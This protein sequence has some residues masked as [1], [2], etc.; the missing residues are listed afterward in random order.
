VPGYPLTAPQGNPYGPQVTFQTE[1]VLPPSALYISRDDLITLE[2]R[3]PIF[4]TSIQL[5]LRYLDPQG[6]LVPELFT[7]SGQ[8]VNATPTI[9]VIQHTEGFLIS[10]SIFGTALGRG[11]VFCKLLLQRG[12]GTQDQTLGHVLCQGYVSSDDMLGYPQSPTESSLSG[13]G[14]SRG[15]NF[16]N[17][18]PGVN[19]STAVPQGVRWLLKSVFAQLATSAA[20][21]NRNPRLVVSPAGFSSAVN[22]IM[23]GTITA[24]KTFLLCWGEALQAVNA[25]NSQTTALPA[26]T[27]LPGTSTIA[28]D[29]DGMDA[30]DQLS[31]ITFLVEEFIGQ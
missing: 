11:A 4:S 9:E 7:F 28:I 2:I 22:C 27:Q 1:G 31:A 15:T 10:A 20:A 23:P 6:V 8:S 16:A 18:A 13:R 3:N 25:S 19:F 17:P 26:N 29:V 14:L 24:S 12:A 5:S 21:G 30:A